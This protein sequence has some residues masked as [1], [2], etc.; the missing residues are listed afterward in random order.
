MISNKH[1]TVISRT[2]LTPPREPRSA[3]QI[4]SLPCS[5][6]Q[7]IFSSAETLRYESGLILTFSKRALL[8]TS[9]IANRG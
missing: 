7:A 8:A 4:G 1:W 6:M 2:V 5:E 3:A 9:A